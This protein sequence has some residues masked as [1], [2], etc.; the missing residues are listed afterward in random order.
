MPEMHTVMLTGRGVRVCMCI[1]V[2]TRASARPPGR[3]HVFLPTRTLSHPRACTF[4]Y[5]RAKLCPHKHTRVTSAQTH[6]HV[7]VHTQHGNTHTPPFASMHIRT[8]HM[9]IHTCAL[10]HKECTH[11]YTRTQPAH[12]LMHAQVR[13]LPHGH[14]HT[15]WRAHIH[16]HSWT[17]THAHR[18]HS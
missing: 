9:L 8:L 13:A 17:H 18:Q 5:T 4:M 12:A 10:S 2:H 3:T 14:T 15:L 1:H 7:C 16:P 6:T 11:R